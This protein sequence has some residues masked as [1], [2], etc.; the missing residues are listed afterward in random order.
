MNTL[1]V[2]HKTISGALKKRKSG[3]YSQEDQRGRHTPHN[4]TSD[5]R[6]NFVKQHIESFPTME[7]HYTRKDTH[8]R[9]LESSLNIRKKYNW[10]KEKCAQ[11]NEM[12]LSERKYRDIFC[13]EYNLSFFSPKK[14]QCSQC[15]A[16]QIKQVLGVASE[17]DERSFNKHIQRKNVLEKRSSMTKKLQREL[18]TYIV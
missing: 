17:S 15:N 18:K 4:K 6:T 13:S 3:T 5:D 14:D 9:Y 1:S 11:E 12:P 16:Y 10:Y 8:R 2:S 7:S